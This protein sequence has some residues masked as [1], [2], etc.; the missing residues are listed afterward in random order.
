[1]AILAIAA[2]IGLQASVSLAAVPAD[3][4]IPGSLEA[5]SIHDENETAHA[6]SGGTLPSKYDSREYGYVTPVKNQGSYG[7]CWAFSTLAAAESS[8]LA[9]GKAEQGKLDL[10]ERHLAYFHYHP[11]ADPLGLM[12]KDS[13]KPAPGKDYLGLGATPMMATFTLASWKGAAAEQ[14]APYSGITAGTAGN[15]SKSIAYT[16]EYHLQQAYWISMKDRADVKEKV[17]AYGAAAISYVDNNSYWNTAG[18]AYCSPGNAGEGHGVTVVGWDDNYSRENFNPIRQPNADGAWLVKNSWGTSKGDKG[19][20]WMSYEDGALNRNNSIAYVFE[21]EPADNY[22]NNYQYDG[23]AS[24]DFYVLKSGST[25]SNVFKTVANPGGSE[26]LKAVSMI[27]NDANVDYSIQVYKSL[28]DP[29]DP[30]SGIPALKTPVKGKIPYAGY[31]TIPLGTD[32]ILPGDSQYAIVIEVSKDNGADIKFMTDTSFRC[33]F[34]ECTNNIEPGESFMRENE[35][36][37]WLDAGTGLGCTWRVKAFTNNREGKLV[38]KITLDQ[39]ELKMKKG[40][41][42]SLKTTVAPTDLAGTKVIYTSSDPQV[43]TVDANGKVTAVGGGTAVIIA[44]AADDGGAS[45]FCVVKVPY[46]INYELGGGTNHMFNPSVYPAGTTVFLYHPE[47]KGYSFEGWYTESSYK[48]EITMLETDKFRE[49][50]LYARWAKNELTLKNKTLMLKK[51]KTYDLG[52]GKKI[53]PKDATIFWY[54]SKSSVVSVKG[55]KITANAVGEATITGLLENTRGSVKDTRGRAIAVTC[56]VT[57]PYDIT[58]KLSGGRNHSGNPVGYYGNKVILKAPSRKGYVFQGWYTDSK[59]KNKITAIK[60]TETKDYTLYAKWAKVKKPKAA[61][62]KSA[63]NSKSKQITLK[64]GKLSGVKGYEISYATDK[65]FKKA[66]RNKTTAKNS[67]TIQGLKKG[68]TY[69]VR[70]RGYQVDS[71]GNKIYGKYSSVKKVKISK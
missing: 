55:G 27:L 56:K 39:A 46:S 52:A 1:M 36:Q 43:A 22:D 45:G 12:A 69:Y 42:Y 11:A 48:H 67:C 16:D 68:K 71:V 47:R 34:Y 58:Y 5:K 18:N 24:T 31:Y 6:S 3:E 38:S 25:V 57:V 44:M 35:K 66:V 15:L 49:L 4:I 21:L 23:T 62:I 9:Q 65:K 53:T 29:K 60:E 70:V 40:E 26:T 61:A 2:A 17:M 33:D 59:Y 10:S 51:G 20:F 13:Y 63:K 64:Y 54:S 32:V 28:S 19:Y 14:S 50:T 8:L 41:T 37:A 30:M 7:T